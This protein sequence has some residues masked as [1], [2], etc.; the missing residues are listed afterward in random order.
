M[1]RQLVLKFG[2]DWTLISYSC[3]YTSMLNLVMCPPTPAML[4]S[5][6]KYI[7]ISLSQ[8]P[9]LDPSVSLYLSLSPYARLYFFS[10][11]ETVATRFPNVLTKVPSTELS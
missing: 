10:P 6:Q 9:C 3:P 5:A 11:Y 4:N 1:V 7:C 2:V 8:C